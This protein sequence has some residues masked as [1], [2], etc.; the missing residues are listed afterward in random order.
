MKNLRYI[1]LSALLVGGLYSCSKRDDV[2][3]GDQEKPSTEIPQVPVDFTKY[4]AIGNSLTSGYADGG[5]YL[6]A[7]S[8]SF[9]SILAEKIGDNTFTQPNMTEAGS[10]YLYSAT[11]G[12]PT[13]EQAYPDADWMKYATAQSEAEK[14]GALMALPKADM[15]LSNLGVPGIRA[16]D[17]G[18]PGYGG[19]NPYMGRLVDNA[20][21]AAKKYVDILQDNVGDA[22][23]FTFWLGNNDVLGF[24]SSGGVYGE[25]G[26]ASSPAYRLD[27]LPELNIF[28]LNYQYMTDLLVEKRGIM[29]TIPP[30]STAPFFTYVGPGVHAAVNGNPNYIFDDNQAAVLNGIY[31]AAGYTSS[32]GNPIFTKG[33]NF[34]IFKTGPG[35]QMLVRQMVLNPNLAP[36]VDLVLLTFGA[37][38]GK[39]QTEGLGLIN[40]PNYPNEY[41]Y[42]VS[43]ATLKV[44]GEAITG[45]SSLSSAGL[46]SKTLDEAVTLSGGAFTKEQA[47]QI[48]QLLILIL[49][50]G[51]DDQATATAKANGMSVDQ[52]ILTVEA[53]KS[54]TETVMITA[55]TAAGLDPTKPEASMKTASERLANPIGTQ[56][57][58]DTDEEVLVSN[59][60]NEINSYIMSVVSV[61]PNWILIDSG[62]LLNRINNTKIDG[63]HFTLNYFSGNVFSMDGIHLTPSGYGI[64]AKEMVKR[65]N[66]D[67]GQ[68]LPD[69]DVSIYGGIKFKDG[70]QQF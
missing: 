38:T 17:M 13:P 33:Q 56:W 57:V 37:E 46:G 31:A 22:T 27:G 43:L 15:P 28:A 25:M 67:W 35:G 53:G 61:N 12:T 55:A 50:Q 42:V 47:D 23:F 41:A 19:A 69:V 70:R 60:T 45:L 2:R 52:A 64:I 16:V 30:V 1:A 66:S 24:A 21:L 26:D 10:G 49:M 44:M 14:L 11:S 6:D 58:L 65:I 8:M 20:E 18:L 68:S 3:E 48:K 5:L 7:Q 51:G 4:V 32:D 9:P 39:L 62:E 34:P 63:V 29:S 59:K 36:A 54:A 40:A